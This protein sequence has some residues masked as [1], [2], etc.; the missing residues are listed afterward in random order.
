[1]S[2]SSPPPPR[3][4]PLRAV[5]LCAG[6]SSRMGWPKGL[7]LVD[8]TALLRAHVDAFTAANLPVTVVL[9][10]VPEAHLA[11]LPP[12]VTVVLNLVWAHT[13]MADSAAMGLSRAGDALLTP[14]D[15]PPA[16]PD[17]LAQ[18]I[19]ARA[20]AVPTYAG[21]RGHPVR[22]SA[23]HPRARLEARL[24]DASEVRVADPHCVRNLNHPEEWA[25]WLAV[26]RAAR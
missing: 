11:V 22:L 26:R 24:T 10:P 3:A 16:Q 1:M 4:P 13:E 23:P 7:L 8:G 5:V 2:S 17:T 19:A 20:P 18:L 25:A 14:V 21:V 12:G 15:A 9:G 6:A